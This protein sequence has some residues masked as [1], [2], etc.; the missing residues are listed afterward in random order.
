MRT[1][2]H[3]GIFVADDWLRD[4]AGAHRTTVAR[5]RQAQRL[6]RAVSVLIRVM[7]DGELEL[8]HPAWAGFK[9]DRRTGEL[10]TPEAWPCTPG[11]L[12]AIKYRM[13]QVR[14]LERELA[15]ARSLRIRSV[16]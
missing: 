10:V 5:W 7:H 4:V 15:I 11:D 8:V 9:L 14:A 1:V 3:R 6:P 13:A 2:E 16:A 12:L